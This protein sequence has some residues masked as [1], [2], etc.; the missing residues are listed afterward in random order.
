M[1]DY[2]AG[3]NLARP[4]SPGDSQPIVPHVD[5]ET[6]VMPTS[7]HRMQERCGSQREG[8]EERD[9]TQSFDGGE[10]SLK[11]S[12]TSNHKYLFLGDYVDRGNHS[13][14]CILFLL[15]LKVAYP[16]RIFLLRG[17]HECRSVTSREYQD[18]LS[19]CA[20][21]ESKISMDGYDCF[22]K[23]FDALPLAAVVENELGRWF[24]CHG[25]LGECLGWMIHEGITH[26]ALHTLFPCF[27]GN[28]G[29][30]CLKA[31]RRILG[32]PLRTRG[33]YMYTHT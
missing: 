18:G 30:Y 10:E 21:C 4:T 2:T 27:Y 31:G 26:L 22:M 7:M 16:D 32:T 12:P 11:L 29:V 15:A 25:G 3:S 23:A 8:A 17:N 6:S 19:F 13:C 28:H 20:E 14:E 33:H 1:F 9:E 5:V 24:C